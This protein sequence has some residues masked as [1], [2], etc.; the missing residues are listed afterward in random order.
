M[1][2]LNHWWGQDLQLSPS[3]DLSTSAGLNEDNQRIFR[4]LCTNGAL[5]GAMVPEYIFHPDYGGSITWYVGKTPPIGVVQAIIRTQ[6]YQEDSVAQNP[7][8]TITVTIN[9][10]GSLTSVISY[11][12]TDTGAPVPPLVLDV[13][14]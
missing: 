4:R 9:P 13:T 3:G 7:E 10:N 11:V 2:D 14:V 5:S 1:A 12:S 6:M 8:P